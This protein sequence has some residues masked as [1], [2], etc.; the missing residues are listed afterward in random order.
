MKDSSGTEEEKEKIKFICYVYLHLL[1]QSIFIFI[2]CLFAF[3]NTFFNILLKK[4]SIIFNTSLIILLVTFFQPLNLEQILKNNS[5]NY[6][7][8]F[9]FTLCISYILCKIAILFDFYLIMITFSFIFFEILYLTIEYYTTKKTKKTK[10]DIANSASFMAFCIILIGSILCF[11]KKIS[12]L[13]FWIILIFLLALDIYLMHYM[14]FILMDKKRNFKNT[15]C[16]LEVVFFYIDI[17]QIILNLFKKFRNYSKPWKKSV[18]K[19]I[20][21]NMIYVGDEEYNYLYKKASDEKDKNNDKKN[22]KRLYNSKINDTI[23]HIREIINQ[24]DNEEK[25][26]GKE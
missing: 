19:K 9:I 18:K 6:I 26:K 13:N 3:Q 4:N 16:T 11:I 24:D 25:K 15:D 17:F 12:V 7:Y 14:N 1:G 2:M 10:T 21:K 8:L 5:Q 20:R 23:E 22:S